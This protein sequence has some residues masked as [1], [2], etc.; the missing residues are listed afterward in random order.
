MR[1][2]VPSVTRHDL[3]IGDEGVD[4]TKAAAAPLGRRVVGRPP[5]AVVRD[6]DHDALRAGLA[7]NEDRTR[8]S[9]VLNRIRHGF[10]RREDD[11]RARRL[12]HPA[13]ARAS[14]SDDASARGR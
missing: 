7:A 8:G 5:V 11:R 12:A 14:S 13:P 9:R 3:S 10:V 2:V 6:L 1:T 4:Q